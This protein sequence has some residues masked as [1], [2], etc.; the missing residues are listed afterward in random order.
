MIIF[1]PDAD[2]CAVANEPGEVQRD[3]RALAAADA[4]G[5][6]LATSNLTVG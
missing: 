5:R 1:E 6:R 3:E 4:L 2:V